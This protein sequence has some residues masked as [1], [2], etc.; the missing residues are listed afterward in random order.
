M[1]HESRD[2]Q[3]QSALVPKNSFVLSWGLWYC[4][5]CAKTRAAPK[6][7]PL[8]STLE[9]VETPRQKVLSAKNVTFITLYF[10][11]GT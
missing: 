11:L 9:V 5:R 4:S 2:L 3:S 6:P 8:G 10:I 1:C 7:A